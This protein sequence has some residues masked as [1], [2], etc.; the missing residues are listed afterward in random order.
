MNLKSNQISSVSTKFLH[1][2]DKM[3]YRILLSDK[4]GNIFYIDFD[5]YLQYQLCHDTIVNALNNSL[6]SID[7]PF[8]KSRQ[9]A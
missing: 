9:H 2:G 3:A 5:K 4:K 6:N 8:I 7:F 1:N